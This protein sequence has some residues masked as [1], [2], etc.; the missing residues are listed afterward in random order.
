MNYYGWQR[1]AII[2]ENDQQYEKVIRI[3]S[4]INIPPVNRVSGS[5]HPLVS[6]F[7]VSVVVNKLQTIS[8]EVRSTHRELLPLGIGLETNKS[9]LQENKA[10]FVLHHFTL[11][12]VPC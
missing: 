8:L 9:Q 11:Q 6:N 1:L 4:I 10:I 7:T 5:A 2:T 3:Y 12:G